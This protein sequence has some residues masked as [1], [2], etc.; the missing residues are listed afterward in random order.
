[1]R[2]H[3]ARQKIA[4]AGGRLAEFGHDRDLLEHV[5]GCRECAQFA[6]AER[7][8]R[9]DLTTA[10]EDD[11]A[12][13]IGWNALRT[14]VDARVGDAAHRPVK[15]RHLMSDLIQN[16][17]RR[18]KWGWALATTVAVLLF[19]T[20]VPFKISDTVGYQVAIAGV[21]PA[22]ALDSDRVDQLLNKLGMNH[23]AFNVSDCD[24]TCHMTI[25][26]LKNQEEVYK[27][28]TAFDHLG[29][30][31]IENIE[32]VEGEGSHSII[33]IMADRMFYDS[34]G[35]TFT[36][37]TD[38]GDSLCQ[39]VVE[40]I[41]ELNEETGGE[42]SVWVAQGCDGDSTVDVQTFVIDGEGDVDLDEILAMHGIPGQTST[43]DMETGENGDMILTTTDADGVEHTINLSDEDAAEQLA[44]LGMDVQILEEG[45]EG[46]LKMFVSKE[47]VIEIEDDGDGSAKTY[48][49]AL[50]EGFRL[51]QNYPNPFNPTT[52]IEFALPQAGPVS[53]E[54]YNINGQKV[55]TLIDG[56]MTAG[57]H[58][59]EWDATDEAGSRVASGVY[60]YRLTTDEFTQSKKMTL[61]K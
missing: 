27:I 2:C 54:I 10:A 31:K 1:M 56:P 9:R 46:A 7:L 30:C 24:H 25:S 8:L 34:K 40:V 36:M 6:Q 50:P 22:F 42:F 41:G 33:K 44:A 60:F 35:N 29:H 52:T 11:N 3:Q 51:E 21:D 55:R 57:V 23:A 49:D 14:R 18:P 39:V 20:L 59:V 16:L 28:R 13:V 61:L 58:T 47:Q 4:A 5:R 53:V 15:E 12:D 48:G 37:S 17:K 26:D 45:E 19:L 38:E 43:I 32:V